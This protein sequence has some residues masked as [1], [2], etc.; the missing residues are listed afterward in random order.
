LFS[1][2]FFFHAAA[3][4]IDVQQFTHEAIGHGVLLVIVG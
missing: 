1:E 3:G 4:Q 2:R